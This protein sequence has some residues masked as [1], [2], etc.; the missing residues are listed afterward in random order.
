MYQVTPASPCVTGTG[1]DSQIIL[2]LTVGNASKTYNFANAVI[3]GPGDFTLGTPTVVDRSN[4]QGL[5]AIYQSYFQNGLGSIRGGDSLWGG[6]VQSLVSEVEDIWRASDFSTGGGR[7]KTNDNVVWGTARPWSSAVT[8]TFYSEVLGSPYNATLG[9]SIPDTTTTVLNITDAATAPVMVHQILVIGTERMRVTAVSGTSVTVIR[10]EQ[11]TTPAS[12]SSGTIQVLGATTPPNPIPNGQYLELVTASGVP[13]NLPQG[14][15]LSRIT[16]TWP[17]FT[18]ADGSNS[19]GYPSGIGGA[20]FCLFP[21]GP[22]T[23]FAVMNVYAT[24]QIPSTTLASPVTGLAST[25]T[26]GLNYP[27]TNISL[28]A[29]LLQI[30]SIPACN[31]HLNLPWN[32]SN[33]LVWWIGSTVKA[34]MPP[35]PRSSSNW[36]TNPG[37]MH[38]CSPGAIAQCLTGLHRLS[39]LEARRNTAFTGH[40]RSRRL[41]N[42]QWGLDRVRS[43]V[44]SIYRPGPIQ[45]LISTMPERSDGHP[46]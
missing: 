30:A 12:H 41:L 26:S 23:A 34:L 14:P 29:L 40:L 21:T 15:H 17:A 36:L 9:T 10:G 25:C 13:H 35:G 33:S 18:F 3:Y 4:P 42:R 6:G 43:W 44:C 46:T 32:A 5:P 24:L 11:G 39:R 8:P 27:D 45:R 2:T 19:Y 28:E 38:S 16:G 31:C 7:I 1:N 20:L 37:T 22:T